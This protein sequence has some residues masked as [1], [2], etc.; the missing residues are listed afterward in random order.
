MV[1][2]D[3]KIGHTHVKGNEEVSPRKKKH[4]ET[5]VVFPSMSVVIGN[6]DGVIHDGA[7]HTY[8]LC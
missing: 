3:R 4:P 8:V 1:G 2:R 6:P 7:A 5:S